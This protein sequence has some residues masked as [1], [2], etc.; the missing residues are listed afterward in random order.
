MSGFVERG[1]A[2]IPGL[3][4]CAD[5]DPDEIGVLAAEV[6]PAIRQFFVGRGADAAD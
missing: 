5:V 6:M 4:G 3:A 2:A 1:R